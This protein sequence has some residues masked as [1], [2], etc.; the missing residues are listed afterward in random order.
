[1]HLIFSWPDSE[2]NVIKEKIS[3]KIKMF[4]ITKR[5]LIIEEKEERRHEDS[6]HSN[7]HPS[8]RFLC[9][10]GKRKQKTG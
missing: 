4:L 2:S 1:M 7:K 10:W 6:R 3:R 9:K 8:D 5:H